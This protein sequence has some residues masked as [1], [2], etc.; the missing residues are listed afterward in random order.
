MIVKARG[1][2]GYIFLISVLLSCELNS[3]DGQN[4]LMGEGPLISE[5]R[6]FSDNF[7]AILHQMPGDIFI[8]QGS[9]PS[10]SVEGQENLLPFL[11]SEVVDGVLALTFTQCVE[12]GEPFNVYVTVTELE[13]VGHSGI[14]NVVFENDIVSPK[15]ELFT[16][17]LGD[18]DLRGA[19]DT[20]EITI[21]GQGNYRGFDLISDRCEILIAGSGD[22]EITANDELFVT[23]NGQG[24]VFYKGMPTVISDINGIGTV[25]DA[26]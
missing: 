7:N 15:L 5:P 16:T 1:Y 21:N 10:L 18:Y 3:D 13:A 17:G 20:V 12:S 6:S 26:N 19:A 25:N 24:N 14:G 11:T 22:V 2:L 4:C 9:F 23:I 8:T